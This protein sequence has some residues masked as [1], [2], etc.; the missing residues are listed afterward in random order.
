MHPKP[1]NHTLPKKNSFPNTVLRDDLSEKA[2]CS[3]GVKQFR[4]H[5]Y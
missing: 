4:R 5:R 1:F 3:P 2:N